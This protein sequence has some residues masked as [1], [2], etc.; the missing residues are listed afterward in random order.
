MSNIPS[1]LPIT[2]QP[3]GTAPSQ[4]VI[5]AP[6]PGLAQ[7]SAGALIEGIVI[8]RTQQGL[9]AVKTSHGEL[10]LRTTASPPVQ[11]R[12]VLQL[13]PSG[14]QYRVILLSVQGT[15][16]AQG[17]PAQKTASPPSGQRAGSQAP[18]SMAQVRAAPPTVASTQLAQVQASAQSAAGAKIAPPV[19]HAAQARAT[20]RPGAQLSAAPLGQSASGPPAGQVF[21]AAGRPAAPLAPLS[22]P[23][24]P[25][26]PSG[27]PV[28]APANAAAPATAGTPT[29]PP[30]S[31][32]PA[33][34][35]TTT[36]GAASTA[37]P[38]ATPG[39]GSGAAGPIN[40]GLSTTSP[41]PVSGQGGQVALPPGGVLA[42]AAGKSV[43]L[44]GAVI[45]SSTNPSPASSAGTPPAGAAIAGTGTS[46]ELIRSWPGLDQAIASLRVASPQLAAPNIDAV[47]PR[48]GPQLAGTLALL[49]FALRGGDIRGWL[50]QSTM[51]ELARSSG[52]EAASR[53]ADE[54]GQLS[55]LARTDSG[56]WR[57]H[58][59]PFFDG[60]RHQQ[61]QLY[62]KHRD[63]GTSGDEDIPARFVFEFD[64]SNLGPIQLDGLAANHRFDLAVR[65]QAK[66]P[67][68]IRNE[69]GALFARIQ[70]E[71]GFAGEI[72]FQTVPSF[73]V[74]PLGEVQPNTGGLVV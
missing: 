41:Q 4:A 9:L 33:A 69:I 64:L 11:S 17:T 58:A 15:K 35:P 59:L 36:P 48:P 30:T 45:L 44:P 1:Y 52:K 51:R 54:F 27:V 56:E 70:E 6:P 65:S 26:T 37:T 14:G 66:L 63:Q 57:V 29:G 55:R 13:Q 22:T 46:A 73:A 43:A 68:A 31:P 67:D 24:V 10:A 34:A 3:T 71:N 2:Q 61:I 62:I 53:L 32:T 19:P 49:V 7:L 72:H 8:G 18:V 40:P 39:A 60:A 28:T 38:A 21:P 74:A 12:V 23:S 47:M 50:G 16:S 5:S 25:T 42:G 20:P